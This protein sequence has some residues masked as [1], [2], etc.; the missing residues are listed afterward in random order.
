MGNI[1]CT[2]KTDNHQ[3][4]KKI[5]DNKKTIIQ[6]KSIDNYRDLSGVS[7]SASSGTG[8]PFPAVGVVRSRSETDIT[9]G[10]IQ[11]D[12]NY[13]TAGILKNS[14]TNNC[15]NK[16][17]RFYSD[18]SSDV[19]P[20]PICP[21][22]VCLDI[23]DKQQKILQDLRN[24]IQYLNDNNFE[25]VKMLS[26]VMPELKGVILENRHNKQEQKKSIYRFLD[27][28]IQQ[29]DTHDYYETALTIKNGFQL[30]DERKEQ[31]SRLQKELKKLKKLLD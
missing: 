26:D 27:A 4:G 29:G 13:Q 23:I 25:S 19:K 1:F 10:V 3:S 31:F 28:I 16:N 8:T 21:R 17:Y 20:K 14:E 5:L 2:P 11:R 9:K 22:V 15:I 30:C 24:D 6:I 18:I 7:N 12:N